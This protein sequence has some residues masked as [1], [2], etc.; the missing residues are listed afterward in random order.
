MAFEIIERDLSGR[1]GRLTTKSGKV[2]TPALLPVIN[3]FLQPIPPRVLKEKFGFDALITNAYIISRNL[4]SEAEDYGIH[5]ILDYDRTI[6]TDSGAYQNLVYGKVETTI[7]EITSFQEKIKTDIAVILDVPTGWKTTREKAVW[8]VEETLKS[9]EKT[10]KIRKDNDIL[11][12]GPIQGGRHLDLIAYSAKKM[13]TLPFQIYALGSPTKVME[14]YLFDTLVD[15]IYITK[16]NLPL[17]KPLHLFGAGHPFMFSLAVALGCDLFDSAAYALYARKGK[18]MTET[19]T[20]SF[21]DLEY[22]PCSCPI[23]AKYSPK[24]IKEMLPTE[25]EK[26]L[27]EHNLYECQ[28]EIRRIKQSITEGRLW[29]LL[30]SRARGHPT[31][32]QALYKFDKYKDYL[33]RNSPIYKKKGFF[34]F[35]AT[36][37]PRPEIVRHSR[38]VLDNYSTPIEK[39]VLLLLPQVANKPFHSTNEFRKVNRILRDLAQG[40]AKK[41]ETCAYAVPFGVIP[42][43][44]DEIYPLT[45]YEATSKLDEES[46]KYVCEEI[47]KYILNGHFKTVVLHFD[48]KWGKSIIEMCRRTCKT[49]GKKYFL[50]Q[51]EEKPWSPQALG[52]LSEALKEILSKAN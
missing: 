51:G 50:S 39:E 34:Y 25:R 12:V 4:K 14:Q 5:K 44:I 46:V 24:T 8:T 23:C 30:E 16:T 47:K 33:E 42:L 36:G 6:M 43:E 40:M 17:D 3:P 27:A 11:W 37:L 41:V 26:A 21:Q 2:E 29:E 45:Q 31:L 20:S 35:N 28:A 49:T 19:G 22:L 48:G 9:A 38:K 15:M 13:G 18:Y 32:L 1:I 52:K 7:E 10:I